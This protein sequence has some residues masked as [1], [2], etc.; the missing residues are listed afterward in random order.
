[1]FLLANQLMLPTDAFRKL[2]KLLIKCF[3]NGICMEEFV[4]YKKGNHEEIWMAKI[5]EIY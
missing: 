3:I 2:I 4:W 5:G 1:M